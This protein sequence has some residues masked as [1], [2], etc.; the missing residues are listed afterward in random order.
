MFGRIFDITPTSFS[1]EV[2]ATDGKAE[3]GPDFSE[4]L[5]Y[6]RLAPSVG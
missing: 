3:L 4:H 2:F 5:T 1:T 6:R